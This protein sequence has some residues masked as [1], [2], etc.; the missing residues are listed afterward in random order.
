MEKDMKNRERELLD[1]L[2]E[3]PHADPEAVREVR[4]RLRELRLEEHLK[5]VKT[6]SK[7]D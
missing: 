3:R 6:V 7:Q 4:R 5:S 2:R 1:W